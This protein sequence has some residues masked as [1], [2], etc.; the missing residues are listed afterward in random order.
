MRQQEIFFFGSIPAQI[1]AVPYMLLNSKRCKSVDCSV[2]RRKGDS[3][4]RYS[5]PYDSLANCWFKPLTHL[6]LQKLKTLRSPTVSLKAHCFVRRLLFRAFEQKTYRF[7]QMRLQNYNFF[8]IYTN[9]P[10]IFLCISEKK[11]NFALDFKR[12][13]V[14]EGKTAPNNCPYK[15]RAC[16]G[17]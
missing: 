1:C 13:L 8:L 16:I 12:R 3:N 10:M 9:F 6:S 15:S 17:H 4:P 14:I 5:Y 11:R 7:C 2:L